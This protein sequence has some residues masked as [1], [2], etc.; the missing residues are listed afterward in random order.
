MH[1]FAFDGR[2]YRSPAFFHKGAVRRQRPAARGWPH[3]P[4]DRR[5][6]ET[7]EHAN[8][9]QAQQAVVDRENTSCRPRNRRRRACWERCSLTVH[10]LCKAGS[11]FDENAE[12]VPIARCGFI[13]RDAILSHLGQPGRHPFGVD[14]GRIADNGVEAA[15][16]D[17]F[18]EISPAVEGFDSA[19]MVDSIELLPLVEIRLNERVSADDVLIQRRQEGGRILAATRLRSIVSCSKSLRQSE[20][21]ATSTACGSMST[22]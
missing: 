4:S 8:S 7:R 14:V 15:A 9:P 12:H 5:R 1:E 21:R 17:D 11:A 2:H 18:P 16:F 6:R 19:L 13:P 3:R 10:P 20:S 22:P